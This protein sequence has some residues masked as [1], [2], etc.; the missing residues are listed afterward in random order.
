MSQEQD[1]QL[2]M[3]A[4]IARCF[5]TDATMSSIQNIWKR[6]VGPAVKRVKETL[7]QGGDPKDL[8]AWG[9]GGLQGSNGSG[10]LFDSYTSDLIFC[11]VL[12]EIPM[13]Y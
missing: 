10:L 4:E 12:S 5:G 13:S 7:D 2:L 3:V 1:C 9:L 6:Q 11:V 8:P